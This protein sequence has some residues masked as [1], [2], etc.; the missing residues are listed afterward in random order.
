MS[1]TDPNPNLEN[2][3]KS[4]KL[5]CCDGYGCSREAKQRINVSAGTFGNVSLNVCP[6]CKKLFENPALR[7]P[8]YE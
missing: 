2:K 3:L 1:L 4:Y 5:I 7:S 8:K 6:D